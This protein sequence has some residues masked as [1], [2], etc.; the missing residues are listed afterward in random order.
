MIELMAVVVPVLV[1]LAL[2]G[3]SAVAG[4][5]LGSYLVKRNER[6]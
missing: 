3:G 6:R 4:I 2:V 5:L 1:F